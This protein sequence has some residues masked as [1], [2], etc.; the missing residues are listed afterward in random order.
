MSRIARGVML[1]V[2][3]GLAWPCA[4]SR[5]APVRFGFGPASGRDQLALEARSLARP[6]AAR[7]RDTHRLL[8]RQPHPAGSVRDHELAA[9][10]AQQFKEAGLQDVQVTRHDVMLPW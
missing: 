4:G 7:I 8:T 1:C 2:A 3:V 6:D 9:W 5:P 10:T